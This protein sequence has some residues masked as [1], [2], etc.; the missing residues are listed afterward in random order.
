MRRKSYLLTAR[1]A[2]DLREARAWSRAR[3]GKELTDRYFEDLHEGAQY[4]AE[5]HA[6]LRDRHELAGGTALLLYP[7]R[8]HYIVYEPLAPRL[9]AIVAVIRQSRDIPAILQKWAAPIRQEVMEIRSK[10]ARG[11]LRVPSR[12]E[13]KSRRRK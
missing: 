9:I 6:S 7:V 2:A 13:P 5:N 12:S 4:I 11:E 3:W 1:A 8:E 10:I